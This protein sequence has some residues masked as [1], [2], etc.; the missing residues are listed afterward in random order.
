MIDEIPNSQTTTKHL[1]FNESAALMKD[2]PE[3]SE[4]DMTMHG[5]N[6]MVRFQTS[7]MENESY[8]DFENDRKI[9][10]RDFMGRTFLVE[11]EGT[12][13]SWKLSGEQSEFLG[14]MCQ[15]ATATVDSTTY[16]A[17]FTP[18]ISIPAGPGKGGLPGLILVLN[19]DDGQRSYVAKELPLE[20]LEKGTIKA[21]KK[22]KKVSQEEFDEIVAE[23]MKEMEATSSGNTFVIRMRN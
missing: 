1:Y 9:D 11:A 19:I 12:N 21:P 8:F 15:K 14:Y 17:W 7:R 10:K 16:E 13:L 6:G 20:P 18:E 2:A 4:Q 3:S 23:K 22:G 5:E